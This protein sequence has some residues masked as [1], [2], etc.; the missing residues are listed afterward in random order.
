MTLTFG[1]GGTDPIGSGAWNNP[2]FDATL[3]GFFVAGGILNLSS[4]Y[5]LTVIGDLYIQHDAEDYIG[6]T[7]ITNNQCNGHTSVLGAQL[8]LGKVEFTGNL[9]LN[10]AHFEGISWDMRSGTIL[11]NMLS[12]NNVQADHMGQIIHRGANSLG[13]YYIGNFT[14]LDARFQYTLYLPTGNVPNGWTIQNITELSPRVAGKFAWF[15]NGATNLTIDGAAVE[16]YSTNVQRGLFLSGGSGSAYRLTNWYCD[17]PNIT[18]TANDQCV[19]FQSDPNDTTTS[20]SHFVA[21]GAW[22]PVAIVGGSPTISYGWMSERALAASGQG[23]LITY[24]YANCPADVYNVHVL[25]SDNTNIMSLAIGEGIYPTCAH[26]DHDTFIGLGNSR[27]AFLGEGT[28]VNQAIHDGYITNSVVT[29]GAWGII[30]GNPNNQWSATKSYNGAGA[31]HNVTHNVSTPYVRNYGGSPGFDNGTVHHPNSLYG[32]LTANPA[33]VAPQLTPESFDSSLGGPG[34]VVHLVQQLAKR[35]GFGGAYDTRYNPSSLVD[36]LR[37]GAAPTN[38]TL[39]QAGSDGT[40]IGAVPGSTNGVITTPAPGSTL[41]G[42]SVVFQWTAGTY[43]TAYWLDAGNVPGGNQYYQS[44]NLGNV[45]TTTAN[46]L[47]T[48]GSTVYVTLYSLVGTQW[49]SNAYTYTAYN[50][51]GALGVITTPAPGSI[52]PGSTVTFTWTAGTYA[53]AYWLDAGNVPGGN[54]YYQSGNLGNV[55][56]TTA[57]GLP[58]DGSTV[59][60]TLYSL[61]G[62]QWMAN[63]YTYTAFSSAGALGVITTPAPGSMLPGSTVT[64]NWTAG[65]YA[66]AYWLDAGNVPGGNQYYQSGNLGNVLTTAANGLP[67]DGSTVYVTLYSLVGTQWLSNAYTYTAFSSAG[68]LGVMQTPTPGSTLSGTVATFTWSAGSGATAYWLD[69]GNVPGGNQYYQSGNLGNILTTTV[70]SLPANGSE[71]YVTLYSLVGGQWLNNA[72]TYTSGP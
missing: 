53:T 24:G 21:R 34:T 69:I 19:K 7:T 38:P 15:P 71:I 1:A 16:G 57:N 47:P 20:I 52:L 61:V 2:G 13:N 72:Y 45:L 41:S 65:T 10:V 64:F 25:E 62:G 28:T 27:G 60:V 40:D 46:G 14:S 12:I 49:L 22:Q 55:L 32:D 11:P 33:F 50:T 18:L 26:Y 17:N 51:G 5:P 30:D 3:H 48:D 29:G 58:T 59:Y 42:S 35:S 9:G 36:F 56:T 31:H 54:Q 67:T 68:A 23:D 44:G 63:A 39:H 8:N 6:C 70:Y 66:T 4:P 43:A 37:Q